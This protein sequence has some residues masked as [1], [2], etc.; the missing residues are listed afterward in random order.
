MS[1]AA[2]LLPCAQDDA[3][4][5]AGSKHSTEHEE[6]QQADAK[7]SK[8]MKDINDD[9]QKT[10]DEQIALQ[11]SIRKHVKDINDD[12]KKTLDE[13]IALQVF[14]REHTKRALDKTKKLQLEAAQALQDRQDSLLA[15]T[16]GAWW[17]VF[18]NNCAW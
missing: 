1:H 15:L 9:S 7:R 2:G 11:N 3:L 13:Q 8:Q 4:S 14:I 16:I 10:L 17:S 12:S 5:N 18:T 6:R